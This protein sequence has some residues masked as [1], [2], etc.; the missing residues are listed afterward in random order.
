MISIWQA[1][2]I[3]PD[4][5]ML[6]RLLSAIDD[7]ILVLGFHKI[8]EAAKVKFVQHPRKAHSVGKAGGEAHAQA[9]AGLQTVIGRAR[10]ALSEGHCRRQ[11]D[12][13][14]KAHVRACLMS[15]AGCEAHAQAQAGLQAVVGRAQREPAVHKHQAVRCAAPALLGP[16]IAVLL[17]AQSC[18]V[19]ARYAAN[20]WACRQ[21]LGARSVSPPS[22]ST[23]LSAVLP[24]PC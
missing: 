8:L 11:T 1:V 22:T 14:I 17:T 12:K 7:V 21:S 16:L 24:P 13:D 23:R 18:L 19:N 9:Q 10:S 5:L 2:V 3:T 15:Q 6:L 4:Q 20:A